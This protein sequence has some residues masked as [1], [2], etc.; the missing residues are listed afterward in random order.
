MDMDKQDIT[1]LIEAA[2]EARQNAYAPYSNF[3][4][5]AALLTNQD[6][7]FC[8]VNVEN[9][10]YGATIC[11]ERVAIDNAVTEGKHHFKAIAIVSG[12]G[13]AYPCGIC[14]Q[15]IAEFCSEDFLVIIAKNIEEYEMINLDELLPK[16]FHLK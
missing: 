7:I 6:E 5:G 15:V 4:V 12:D 14:R 8:G 9:A 13:F 1:R 11:A 10:S 2:M 3:R 16:A